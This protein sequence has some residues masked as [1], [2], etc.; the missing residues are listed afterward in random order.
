MLNLVKTS[1]ETQGRNLSMS[2][3]NFFPSP[4]RIMN[5]I[6]TA[7]LLLSW[8]QNLYSKDSHSHTCHVAK[9]HSNVPTNRRSIHCIFSSNQVAFPYLQAHFL[10]DIGDFHI[11]H[12]TTKGYV[13]ITIN[14]FIHAF[15]LFIS[16]EP[17]RMRKNEL[18]K[19]YLIICWEN[20]KKVNH[21]E[22]NTI[23]LVI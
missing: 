4:F 20:S 12:G 5:A 9:V 10:G 15:Q 3:V 21:C 11:T 14:R 18:I 7:M 19:R 17:V 2:F 23:Y 13:D 1:L 22:E 16:Y 6:N 8:I